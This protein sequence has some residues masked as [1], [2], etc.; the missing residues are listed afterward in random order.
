MNVDCTTTAE[1]GDFQVNVVTTLCPF[2]RGDDT[3]G[4]VRHPSYEVEDETKFCS[5]G[6]L[7]HI[8]A[9]VSAIN[10][11]GNIDSNADIVI[12]R[13]VSNAILR[14]YCSLCR[15]GCTVPDK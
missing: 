12:F 9:L 14:Q 5:S 10:N 8:S 13:D 15:S 1:D 2:L 11:R 4:S 7:T 3:C 6:C